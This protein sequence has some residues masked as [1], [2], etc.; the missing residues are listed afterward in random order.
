[1]IIDFSLLVY[2]GDKYYK[3]DPGIAI[4]DYRALAGLGEDW[5]EELWERARNHY[6]EHEEFLVLFHKNSEST[7]QDIEK[8]IIEK[9]GFEWDNF[10][11]SYTTTALY[12]NGEFVEIY[13]SSI[14]LSTIEKY[15]YD[16]EDKIQVFFIFSNQAGDI[17]VEDGLRYYMHSRESGRHNKPHIHID[18]RHEQDVSM[19]LSDGSVLV[20]SIPPKALKK[21][22]KRVM[23]NQ[24]FLLE[25]WNKQT[26]GLHVDINHFLGITPLEI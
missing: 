13:D 23:D 24:R 14:K 12:M 19:S 1:M 20:G 21:A 9:A 4:D 3:G 26:D 10:L 17:W 5:S 8:A 2:D 15:Y 18:Y 25:C 11:H 22:R 7:I 6:K 16:I